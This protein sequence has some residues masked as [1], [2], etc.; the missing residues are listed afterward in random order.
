MGATIAADQALKHG[1]TGSIGPSPSSSQL[2]A[3]TRSRM[4]CAV[5]RENVATQRRSPS[6]TPSSTHGTMPFAD[7]SSSNPNDTPTCV[8]SSANP[9]VVACANATDADEATMAQTSRTIL[10]ITSS[11]SLAP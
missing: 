10:C 9:I 3:V 1:A 6:N 4:V 5:A 11:E 2:G 8:A 7:V